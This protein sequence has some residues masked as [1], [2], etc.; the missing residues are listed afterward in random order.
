MLKGLF[1]A[2]HSRHI[3]FP[4]VTYITILC[5]HIIS[6]TLRVP[7]A[8]NDRVFPRI[9][10][11]AIIW[12]ATSRD[13]DLYSRSESKSPYYRRFVETKMA[14][15]DFTHLGLS[16]RRCT[17]F[18]ART[19]SP[20]CR[21]PTCIPP[22][23]GRSRRNRPVVAVSPSNLQTERNVTARWQMVC[24]VGEVGCFTQRNKTYKAHIKG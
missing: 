16:A 10:N 6:T 19:R 14:D 22:S 24:L 21:S 5:R 9:Y 15:I 17:H 18:R 1:D 12:N 11:I 2:K 7:S 20:C 3:A 23:P 13:I 4:I 8:H